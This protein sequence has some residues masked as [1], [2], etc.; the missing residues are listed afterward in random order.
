MNIIISGKHMETG[1]ALKTHVEEHLQNS[2]SKYFENAIDATVVFSKDKNIFSCH[3]TVDEG[4][5]DSVSIT[6]EED[7]GDVYEA[8]NKALTKAEKQLRR[9][10]RKLNDRSRKL[11]LSQLNT[12]TGS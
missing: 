4:V 3:I 6:A 12:G 2:V 10:K 1:E 9:Y 8:F 7:A 5:K 11:G